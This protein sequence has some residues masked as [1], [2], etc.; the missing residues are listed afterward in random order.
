MI[1]I[2]AL[3]VEMFRGIRDLDLEFGQANFGIRG[4]NGTGKS[5]VVDAI[6]FCLTGD[7]TRLSGEGS[8]DV[9][10]AKHGPHVDVVDD[11]AKS[12]VTIRGHLPSLGKDV[13]ITR[14]IA[15]HRKPEIEPDEPEVIAAMEALSRHPEFALSRR[16][17]V[18]YIITAPG[19]R[20]KDVQT[21]LR[22]DE[23]GKVR[24]ALTATANKSRSDASRAESEN[25]RSASGF[26][27]SLNLE[28]IG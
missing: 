16:E 11:P 14:S 15:Q 5:G 18:K 26:Q 17:I 12:I 25:M 23:L 6:E 7:I 4:P 22:L 19:Q 2:E 1:K 13:T 3:R 24:S 9:S 10:V 21:L 20:A 8:G 28:D 27:Q